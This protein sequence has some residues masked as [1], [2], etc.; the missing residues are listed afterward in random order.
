MEQ[1]IA[2]DVRKQNTYITNLT[3]KI[4][5]AGKDASHI[6]AGIIICKYLKHLLLISDITSVEKSK[7]NNQNLAQLVRATDS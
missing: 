1:L 5:N 2:K 7:N 6:Q 4:T 3:S